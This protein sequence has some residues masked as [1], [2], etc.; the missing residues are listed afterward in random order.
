MGAACVHSL[1]RKEKVNVEKVASK[2]SNFDPPEIGTLAVTRANA[3]SGSRV[4]FLC[5]CVANSSFV[6]L[7]FNFP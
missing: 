5:I 4:H 3:E 1:Q 6:L 2:S 7:S